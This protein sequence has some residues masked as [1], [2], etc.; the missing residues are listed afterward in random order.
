MISLPLGLL[1]FL[2]VMAASVWGTRGSDYVNVHSFLVVGVGTCA[3]FFTSTDN[4]VIKHVIKSVLT[5][6]KPRHSLKN[7]RSD[8]ERLTENKFSLK[9]S[10]DPLIQY[11][12]TL[13]ERGLDSHSFQAL[14]SQYRDKL[15]TKDVE[16]ISALQNIAKYPP[17]LGMLG[18]VMGMITLFANLGT[19]DK[20]GLGSALAVAMTAT[21][22]GLFLANGIIMPLADRI[23]VE[24]M[25]R[26]QHFNFVSEILSLINRNE[27]VSLIK[28]EIDYREAS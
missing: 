5:M 1:T 9:S 2:V 20:A 11:A 7:I 27:S 15:E 6:F 26:K 18:T 22:Y 24:A 8:L 10:S 16:A 21:F 17:A 19:S 12:I 28:E 4:S 3:V 13:W 14:M 23:H 25:H